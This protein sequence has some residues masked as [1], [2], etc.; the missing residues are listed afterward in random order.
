[1]SK[2]TYRA[3]SYKN[4][5]EFLSIDVEQIGPLK[6]FPERY[7]V[8]LGSTLLGLDCKRTLSIPLGF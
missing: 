2:G 8:V 4:G 5:A 6:F 3:Y 7:T 1:M